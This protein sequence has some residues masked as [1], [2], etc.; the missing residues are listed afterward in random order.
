MKPFLFGLLLATI[1]LPTP[2]TAQRFPR[3]ELA[4]L[5]Q[6]ALFIEDLDEDAKAC[7]VNQDA[8]E[9]SVRFI[10]QQSRMRIG[11]RGPGDPH[12]YVS[13]TALK[14]CSVA[15]GLSVGTRVVI[16]RTNKAADGAK[17]W[18]QHVI[19]AGP[20]PSTAKRVSDD[21]ESMMKELVVD[22]SGAN[23]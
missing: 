19:S 15:V 5:N 22:W 8:I 14:N 6:F 3:P 13:I 18:G 23:Q 11:A 12:I 2:S 7:G 9:T 10:A 21:V 4:G 17:I 20:R 1:L 16:Q